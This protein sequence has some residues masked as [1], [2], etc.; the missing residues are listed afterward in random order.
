MRDLVLVESAAEDP[1]LVVERGRV[2]RVDLHVVR[3][4]IVWLDDF[5]LFEV[6]VLQV[7]GRAFQVEDDVGDDRGFL[8]D[9]FKHFNDLT[10]LWLAASLF[11]DFIHMI[12]PF[13][14]EV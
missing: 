6:G 8:Q 1:E 3:P 14:E 9:G 7:R 13:I 11:Y 5:N 12:V 2:D 4:Q 10:A